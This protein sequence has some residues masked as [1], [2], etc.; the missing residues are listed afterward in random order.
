MSATLMSP[1]SGQLSYIALPMCLKHSS[2][3]CCISSIALSISEIFFLVLMIYSSESCLLMLR[4]KQNR[5][6]AKVLD[7]L[8]TTAIGAMN[9]A[10][11]SVFDSRDVPCRHR[12]KIDVLRNHEHRENQNERK[13]D[14][15]SN[16]LNRLAPVVHDFPLRI[17]LGIP[18]ALAYVILVRHRIIAAIERP[19]RDKRGHNDNYQ[20]QYGDEHVAQQERQ[21]N[22]NERSE[23]HRNHRGRLAIRHVA[24]NLRCDSRMA[25]I[26]TAEKR[27]RVRRN[28]RLRSGLRRSLIRFQC[29]PL[30]RCEHP[31]LGLQVQPRVL[32]LGQIRHIP[33]PP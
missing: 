18:A 11:V 16:G 24:H 12:A 2:R 28:G 9:I 21:H 14:A 3:R 15:H 10:A 26:R 33:N 5:A 7:G 13:T 8:L 30:L 32:L 17:P 20:R 23:H 4:Q 29:S 19:H 22:R 6:V 31:A 27:F 25:A 1:S